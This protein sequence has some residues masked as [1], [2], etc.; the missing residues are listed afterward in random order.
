MEQMSHRCPAALPIGRGWLMDYHLLFRGLGRGGVATVEPRKGRRVPILLWAITETCEMSL[1]RYEGY[2][3]LYRKEIVEVN[4]IEWLPNQAVPQAS[5]PS[6][7]AMI[8]IMNYGS[9]TPPSQTYL[10]CIKEGYRTFAFHQ[11]YLA[12]AVRRTVK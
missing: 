11:R 9:L 3:S 12:E 5:V 10:D 1:D 7:E 8:Y 4:G 6:V 2:P